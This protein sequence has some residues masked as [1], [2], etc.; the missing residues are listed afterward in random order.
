MTTEN[1]NKEAPKPIEVTLLSLTDAYTRLKRLALPLKAHEI[2]WR[3]GS[4]SNGK[5]S[6]LAYIDNRTVYDRFDALFSIYWNSSVQKCV[7]FD[8]HYHTSKCYQHWN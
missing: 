7:K 5:T 6:V 8:L 3:V 4:K 2:E 1:E